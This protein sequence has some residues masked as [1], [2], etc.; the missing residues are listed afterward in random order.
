[1]PG[2]PPPPIPVPAGMGGVPLPSPPSQSGAHTL[3]GMG[4]PPTLPAI[5]P[6]P[7][8]GSASG[9]PTR[10]PAVPAAAL[11]PGGRAATDLA[12]PLEPTVQGEPPR[13]RDS[14]IHPLDPSDLV[15][16]DAVADLGEAD[17][18]AENASRL[19]AQGA[20]PEPGA[21][22]QALSEEPETHSGDGDD[23]DDAA[24]A[25]APREPAAPPPMPDRAAGFGPSQKDTRPIP[26]ETLA[27][28]LFD[29]IVRS[30]ES[31]D[32]GP[33]DD[34]G[35]GGYA[36]RGN[37]DI[38]AAASNGPAPRAE[39]SGP[40]ALSGAALGKTMLGYATP[41]PTPRS[42]P[43]TPWP[44]PAPVGEHEPS[45]DEMAGMAL[46]GFHPA[47]G[48][49]GAPGQGPPGPSVLSAWRESSGPH[50]QPLA[51]HP[52]D[53]S[54]A[55][56]QN[57]TPLPALPPTYA[58]GPS[59]PTGAMSDPPQGFESSAQQPPME[60]PP[61]PLA[62]PQGWATPPVG[63]PAAARPT[64]PGPQRRMVWIL[65]GMIGAV[66]VAI[67]G[68]QIY[69]SVSTPSDAA[70]T[71]GTAGTASPAPADVK[72]PAA[73]SDAA[74]VAIATAPDAA[75]IAPSPDAAKV[76]AAPSP[77]AAVAAV[78]AATP[79]DARVAIAPD[80]AQVAAATPDSA[81]PRDASAAVAVGPGPASGDALSIASTPAGA[82]IFLDGSDRGATPV[83]LPGSPDRHN[84][85]LLL[86]GHEL[87]VAQVDGH[88]TFQIPLKEVTPTNG[89]AGIKVL[90]CK[91][92][93]R[94]YVFVDGKPTGQT[95]P[96]ER[97][98]CE[99][100]P[101]TVEVYDVVS[102]TRRK[103]DIVVKDTR[104]SFRIRVE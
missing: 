56:P 87:Y 27:P 19:N 80:A 34:D 6:L 70:G 17:T 66:A 82:R 46:E 71:R 64:A 7:R 100:G 22:A 12:V 101:H 78:A 104:L 9:L 85:A 41:V 93:D 55:P 98:G 1:M 37:A 88:G 83:K 99:V 102:E 59:G 48:P 47:P 89:P 44:P 11:R 16:Y 51:P 40:N 24:A 81:P 42:Q 61:L 23:A 90:R 38:A 67:G 73:T 103:W 8:P 32:R 18:V 58:M 26:P 3:L 72:A 15:P 36:D 4:R 75:E 29:P 43:A 77:D 35:A 91:D 65:V 92:K 28:L 45:S 10:P 94:Y 62:P 84:L 50:G 5:K 96:T 53:A 63:V 21:G 33:D 49:G 60:A 68:W 74:A 79:V 95:C 97:I 69:A 25:A 30:P 31:D 86:A 20:G 13:E 2:V 76:A 14:A 57:L 54:S 39:A 52:Q